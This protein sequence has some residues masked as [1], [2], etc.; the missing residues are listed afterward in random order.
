MTTLDKSN[1]MSLV[2][3]TKTA[4]ILSKVYWEIRNQRNEL[5]SSVD[6][7]QTLIYFQD[8]ILELESQ[9]DSSL[10]LFCRSSMTGKWAISNIGIGPVTATRLLSY[11]DIAKS[12]TPEHLWSY[13]G[14]VPNQ[15]G[16][17]KLTYN[18]NLKEVCI[19]LGKNFVKYSAKEECF[20]G[21]LYLEER[22]RRTELNE[23]GEYADLANER[24]KNTL[25]QTYMKF[26]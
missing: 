10:E 25:L 22:K 13:A 23:Q 18:N 5:T 11:I 14:L 15:T 3:N 12:R 8:L 21:H 17:Q 6:E 2:L 20:Y 9:M 16:K 7:N 26:I 19:D 24:I 4:S 1:P